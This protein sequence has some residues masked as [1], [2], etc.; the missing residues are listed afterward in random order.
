MTNGLPLKAIGFICRILLLTVCDKDVWVN[1]DAAQESGKKDSL[2][3]ENCP[4]ELKEG[5]KSSMELQIKVC[6]LRDTVARWD[7]ELAE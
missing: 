1:E 2:T 4:Q 7:Y 3:P 5:L 6:S